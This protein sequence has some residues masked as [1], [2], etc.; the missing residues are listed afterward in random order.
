MIDAYFV[1][2]EHLSCHLTTVCNCD[3]H[4]IVDLR[5]EL[6]D[7]IGRLKLEC[8]VNEGKKSKPLRDFAIQN[9]SDH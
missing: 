4:S 9:V 1:E 6:S 7:L 3:S 5:L 2:C 8:E